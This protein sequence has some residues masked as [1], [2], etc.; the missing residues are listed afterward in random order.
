MTTIDQEKLNN[1]LIK[2][3]KFA[4]PSESVLIF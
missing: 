2:Y 3:A 1:D 4:S